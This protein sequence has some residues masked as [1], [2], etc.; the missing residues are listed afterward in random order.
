MRPRRRSARPAFVW[1][2]SEPET[3]SSLLADVEEQLGP[4]DI[5]VCNTGGPPVQQDPLAA[6]TEQWRQAYASLVLAPIELTRLALPAMRERGWGRVLNVVSAAAREPNPALILSNAHR[7]ATLAAW[8]TL[9]GEFAA[10]GVTINSLLPGMIDTDRLRE[11]FGS[12]DAMTAQIPAKRLG[13]VEE[14]AAAAAFL[15]STRASYITGVALLVD[16]GVT[17]AV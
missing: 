13:T 8:K 17:R 12:I 9:A 6:T 11:N 15:C 2:T 7:S 1:D 16:G 4:I 3:A 5:L 14:M 10:G